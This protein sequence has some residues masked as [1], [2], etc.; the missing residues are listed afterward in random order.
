MNLQDCCSTHSTPR[1]SSSQAAAG[2]RQISALPLT[3]VND[4][5]DPLM[6]LTV[7]CYRR[8]AAWY[9]GLSKSKTTTEAVHV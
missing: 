3:I 2:R 7:T 4:P 1:L 5:G 6:P 9:I 8:D